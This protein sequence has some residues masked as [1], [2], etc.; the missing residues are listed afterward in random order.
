MLRQWLSFLLLSLHLFLTAKVRNNVESIH[1]LCHNYWR[2]GTF[3]VRAHPA[4]EE[5]QV[6]EDACESVEGNARTG[7]HL[8]AESGFCHEAQVA[9]CGRGGGEEPTFIVKVNENNRK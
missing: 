9:L 1:I 2:G 5:W 6:C 3:N 4:E 7:Y 8:C